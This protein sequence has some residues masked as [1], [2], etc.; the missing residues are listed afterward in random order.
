MTHE[1]AFYIFGWLVSFGIN[2]EALR[3]YRK[4]SPTPAILSI[5]AAAVLAVIWPVWI[6]GVIYRRYFVNL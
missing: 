6:G 1:I 4:I 3:E 2:V 5:I